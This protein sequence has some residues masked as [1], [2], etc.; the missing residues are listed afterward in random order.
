MKRT[1]Y[2]GYI[3]DD[4]PSVQAEATTSEEV[5]VKPDPKGNIITSDGNYSVE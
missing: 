2:N 3:P 4:T 5:S 1:N